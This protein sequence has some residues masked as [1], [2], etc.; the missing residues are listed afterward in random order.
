MTLGFYDN[1]PP[2]IHYVETFTSPLSSRQLQQR[3]IQLLGEVNRKETSFEE[4]AIPTIPDGTVIFEFGLAEL[5]NFNYLSAEEVTRAVAFLAKAQVASL[6]F[7]C[8]I[9]Y[10]KGKGEGEKRQA[11][12]FDYYMLRTVFGKG[13]FEVQVFHERGPRYLSPEDLV[14]FIA[15]RLNGSSSRKILKEATNP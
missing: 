1:F 9:R 5:G 4:V 6:D 15:E 3:L 11:L 10:Y 2:N 7:F 14:K 8:S 13:T 12:K